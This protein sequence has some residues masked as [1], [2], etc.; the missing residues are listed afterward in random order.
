MNAPSNPNIVM[1]ANSQLCS[2]LLWYAIVGYCFIFIIFGVVKQMHQVVLTD[3][4][5]QIGRKI[6][7][8]HVSLVW[9]V[10]TLPDIDDLRTVKFK[11]QR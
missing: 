5:D 4:R 7:I 10:R 6:E 8:C 9:H 1:L 11:L 2:S 3:R